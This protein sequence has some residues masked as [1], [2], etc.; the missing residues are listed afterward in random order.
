MGLNNEDIQ[1][2]IAILQRGLAQNEETDDELVTTKKK[3]KTKSTTTK[4]TKPKRINKFDQMPE[5]RMHKEDVAID[6][7]LHK[8]PPTPRR[9]EFRP[10]RIACRVCGQTEAVD[11]SIIESTDR[12]KCNKCSISAG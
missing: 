9:D 7:K 10:V 12:Y 3:A 6:K 2:L 1:Q 11:P 5:C 4:E 8:A